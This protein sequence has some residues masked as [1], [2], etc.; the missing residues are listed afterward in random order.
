MIDWTAIAFQAMTMSNTYLDLAHDNLT[1]QYFP[2]YMIKARY[3]SRIVA[4]CLYREDLQKGIFNS[5][6]KP[7]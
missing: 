2:G 3:Y 4:Y 5:K 7:I 6:Y 1:T